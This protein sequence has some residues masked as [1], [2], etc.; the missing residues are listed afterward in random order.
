MEQQ[1]DNQHSQDAEQNPAPATEEDVVDHQEPIVDEAPEEGYHVLDDEPALQ[2]GA[3]GVDDNSW[4][5]EMLAEAPRVIFSPP[6]SRRDQEE[7]P[8]QDGFVCLPF[9]QGELDCTRCLPVHE[10]K[11]ETGDPLAHTYNITFLYYML[12]FLL[13][14]VL[15]RY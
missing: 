3:G 13:I 2:Q 8:V 9:A 1:P 10:A 15:L 14:F 7:P 11:K 4:V 5:V 12:I 6:R